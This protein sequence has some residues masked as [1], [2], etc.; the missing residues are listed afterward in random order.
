M[1]FL[2]LLISFGLLLTVFSL[3]LGVFSMARG[4]SFDAE[5]ATQLM[6]FR[7]ASQG[8]TLLLLVIALYVLNS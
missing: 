1:A 5:H 4:G 6:L 7:V 8:I 2:T 3:G